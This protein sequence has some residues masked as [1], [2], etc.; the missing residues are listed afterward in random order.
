MRSYYRCICRKNTL[1]TEHR[2]NKC[3]SNAIKYNSGAKKTA[4]V[5]VDSCNYSV[6]TGNNGD[7]DVKSRWHLYVSVYVRFFF[8]RRTTCV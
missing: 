6:K 3:F 2:E 4:V 7:T 1:P 8:S 5:M